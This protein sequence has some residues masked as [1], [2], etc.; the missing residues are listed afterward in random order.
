MDIETIAAPPPVT[1]SQSTDSG[2]SGDAKPK[3]AAKSDAPVGETAAEKKWRLK[4]GKTEREVTEKELIAEAQKGWASDEKFKKAMAKEREVKEALEKGD[5]DSIIKKMKGKSKLDFAREVLKEEL[6]R[7]QRTPEEA[8][9]EEHKTAIE[10]LRKERAELEKADSERKLS[11]ATR[12]YE[13]QYDRELASAIEKH[14]IPKNKYVIG[15]AV[16]IATEIVN[17]DLEPD[18]DLVVGEAKRQVQEELFE[19]MDQMDDYGILG[20]D[21]ARKISKWLVS[22]GMTK[23]QANKEAAKVVK[24]SDA[25]PESAEPVDAEEYWER[26]RAE[27]L[28]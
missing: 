8:E 6:N 24:Q 2:G 5:L 14:K 16:K 20:E 10:R 28:K 22:K 7:L 26:K 25:S 11:E 21:R 12:H 1:E 4:F 15:R 9:A 19:L 3:E 18:W 27:F 23:T 17:Q 13:E